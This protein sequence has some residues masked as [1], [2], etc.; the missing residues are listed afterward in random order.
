M[1]TRLIIQ[2]LRIAGLMEGSSFLLLIFAA[3][4]MKYLLDMPIAVKWVGWLHGILF[5]IFCW[6]LVQTVIAARWKL[7]EGMIVL[8]A[9]LVPFGPFI[10]DK[11]LKAAIQSQQAAATVKE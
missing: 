8:L 9:A 10:I 1:E 5:I 2:R 3:M 4:P 7:S 6:L 11:R